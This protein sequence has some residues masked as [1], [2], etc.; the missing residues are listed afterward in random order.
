MSL[1]KVLDSSNHQK[2]VK[3]FIENIEYMSSNNKNQMIVKLNPDHLGRMDIK[4][5]VV[6]DNIRLMIKVENQDAVKFMETTILDIRNMI[7][8]VH[9][10]NL[11]NIQV[12]LQ[13][14]GFN[15][16]D[17]RGN[18]DSDNSNSSTSK[19]PTIKIE[20]EGINNDDN[21]DLRKGI[22]V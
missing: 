11:E 7:K 9:N 5:E 3:E 13:E 2:F 21:R 19:T 14:F 22:L 8:E 15:P 20:D 6:K 16:N 12:D 1:N 10:I 4:Y 18:K 17:G